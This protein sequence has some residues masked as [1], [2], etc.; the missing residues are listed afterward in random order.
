M[1]KWQ[2]VQQQP[3]LKEVFKGPPML[4]YRKRRSLRHTHGSKIITDEGEKTGDTV[5]SCKHL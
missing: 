1:R 3:L 2:L 5:E 4:S